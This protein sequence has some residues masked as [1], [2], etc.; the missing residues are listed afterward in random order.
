MSNP[1]TSFA[2]SPSSAS[3]STNPIPQRAA[4]PPR[5][6]FAASVSGQ[7]VANVER[8]EDLKRRIDNLTYLLIGLPQPE[9]GPRPTPGGDLPISHAT[10]ALENVTA[11]LNYALSR[12]EFGEN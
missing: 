8:L 6:L 9:E 3:A 5:A 2:P 12:L 4:E 10:A 1:H 11:A 7:I